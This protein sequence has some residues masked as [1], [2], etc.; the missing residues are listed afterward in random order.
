MNLQEYSESLAMRTINPSDLS[1]GMKFLDIATIISLV[2]TALPMLP[3]FKNKSAAEKRESTEKNPELA[4]I[5]TAVEFRKQA[6]GTG[7]KIGRKY[8]REL[9]ETTVND[10]LSTSDK[11]IVAMGIAL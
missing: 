11:D 2:L 9:A 8:A 3:C 1:E 10:Y 7:E 5:R 6:R 4:I